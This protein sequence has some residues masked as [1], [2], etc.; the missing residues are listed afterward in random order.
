MADEGSCAN[1]K[2]Y[3]E[4]KNNNDEHWMFSDT[5]CRILLETK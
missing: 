5:T 4:E 3:D 1:P 2:R